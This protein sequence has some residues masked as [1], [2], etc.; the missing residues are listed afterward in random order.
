ML[1]T[2]DLRQI[3]CHP[4]AERARTSVSA[5]DTGNG[6]RYELPEEELQTPSSIREQMIR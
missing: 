2:W 6:I 5:G 1:A 4:H 3:S